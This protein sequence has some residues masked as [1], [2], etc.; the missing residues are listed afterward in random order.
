MRTISQSVLQQILRHSRKYVIQEKGVTV[1]VMG[2]DRERLSCR[3]REGGKQQ[4]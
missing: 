1:D 3:S 4:R 2:N